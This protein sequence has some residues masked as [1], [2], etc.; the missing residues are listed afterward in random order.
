MIWQELNHKTN[1]SLMLHTCA[2]NSDKD[3]MKVRT[4]QGNWDFHGGFWA[5]Q[6]DILRHCP[7]EACGIRNIR[8]SKVTA[9][10]TIEKLQRMVIYNGNG[11]SVCIGVFS[12]SLRHDFV[13][14][15]KT[16]QKKTISLSGGR[17]SY[18][19]HY[20]KKWSNFCSV[21]FLTANTGFEKVCLYA[22]I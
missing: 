22:Y 20:L 11:L 13:D 12:A 1:N 3:D 14:C 7:D 21:K 8:L 9:Y 19:T 17:M 5:L 4:I 15:H 18:F 2:W 10:N 6:N 16:H